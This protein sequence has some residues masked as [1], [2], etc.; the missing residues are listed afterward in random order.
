MIPSVTELDALGLLYTAPFSPQVTTGCDHVL[1]P[2]V[3][4]TF[5]NGKELIHAFLNRDE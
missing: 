2:K 1:I 4:S 5:T 3:L